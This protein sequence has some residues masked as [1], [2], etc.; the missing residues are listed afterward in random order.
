MREVGIDVC[1]CVLAYL[2]HG[3][4]FPSQ[5]FTKLVFRVHCTA[6]HVTL[7]QDQT[8]SR[9]VVLGTHNK[10]RAV[11]YKHTSHGDMR[12]DYTHICTHWYNMRCHNDTHTIA[13]YF[14]CS[15]VTHDSHVL[16]SDASRGCDNCAHDNNTPHTHKY[17]PGYLMHMHHDET[18]T[19]HTTHLNVSEVRHHAIKC[20]TLSIVRACSFV[21]KYVYLSLTSLSGS[22]CTCMCV[23]TAR[24]VPMCTE[25]GLREWV[26][27]CVCVCVRVTLLCGPADECLD[28]L[29]EVRHELCVR[30]SVALVSL[31]CGAIAVLSRIHTVCARTSVV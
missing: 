9:T 21:F 27:V 30:M 16:F 10:A 26:C 5:Y 2:F 23:F 4:S 31:G 11:T 24:R 12:C 28:P 13:V 17:A 15:A 1:M 8:N 29:W 22:M 3:Q 25:L 18:T 14:F 7:T 6:D 20:R 19:H